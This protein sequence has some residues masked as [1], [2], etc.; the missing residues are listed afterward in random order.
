M[1]RNRSA[2][3]MARQI[4]QIFLLLP[5]QPAPLQFLLGPSRQ[6][7]VHQR[8]RRPFLREMLAKSPKKNVGD[9]RRNLLCI[10]RFAQQHKVIPPRLQPAR[11]RRRHDVAHHRISLKMLPCRRPIGAYHVGFLAAPFRM[12][13]CS[14]I[15][16]LSGGEIN[17]QQSEMDASYLVARRL[18]SPRGEKKDGFLSF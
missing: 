7:L 3:K 2:Q 17:N 9:D 15:Y 16:P 1:I 8:R 14:L 4:D 18:V 11:P 13:L 6:K 12:N 5:R 10:N